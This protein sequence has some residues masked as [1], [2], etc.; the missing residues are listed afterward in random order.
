[1]AAIDAVQFALLTVLIVCL[2][3]GLCTAFNAIK[4]LRVRFLEDRNVRGDALDAQLKKLRR[5]FDKLAETEYERRYAAARAICPEAFV[6]DEDD[7]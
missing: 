6:G 5:D 7:E 3:A 2:I 1:M 4:E